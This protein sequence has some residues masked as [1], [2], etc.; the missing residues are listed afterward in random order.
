MASGSF[1]RKQWSAAESFS[2]QTGRGIFA[3]SLW[4]Q[5]NSVP[6]SQKQE[7]KEK[8]NVSVRQ[9]GL[10]T[11]T[12]V[13]SQ[14]FGTGK[15]AVCQLFGSNC[16]CTCPYIIYY[17]YIQHTN[18]QHIL[19]LPCLRAKFQLSKH[20]R[21]SN[22][23]MPRLGVQLSGPHTGWE[24]PLFYMH[25]RTHT[26]YDWSICSS[27]HSDYMHNCAHAKWHKDGRDQDHLFSLIWFKVN[28][29][30]L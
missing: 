25:T 11:W 14:G 3:D 6:L 4:C 5:T 12:S 17:T 20:E 8:S 13:L 10:L 29:K 21:W 1:T 30:A 9:W 2:C 15:R 7:R 19:S 16:L 28:A 23:T 27:S 26:C 18:R 24:I 22:E